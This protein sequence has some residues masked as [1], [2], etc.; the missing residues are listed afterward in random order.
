MLKS[1]M[2]DLVGTL[3][4]NV[5]RREVTEFSDSDLLGRL[6]ALWNRVQ[7]YIG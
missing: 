1:P 5:L 6:K 2:I 4:R 7:K 3:R